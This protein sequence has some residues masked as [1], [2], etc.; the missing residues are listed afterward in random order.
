MDPLY[1]L[2]V[3]MLLLITAVFLFIWR[4]REKTIKDV[5]EGMDLALFLV[6]MPE[7]ITGEEG[8]TE[9]LRHM[10]GKMENFLMGL[11]SLK[12]KKSAGLFPRKPIFALEIAAHNKGDE[13]F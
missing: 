9:A 8:K 6:S 5:R 11:G 10:I 7:E 12:P 3:L 2:L 1:F 13:I 4:L